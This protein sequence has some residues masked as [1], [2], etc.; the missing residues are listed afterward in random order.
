MKY[1]IEISDNDGN[2]CRVRVTLPLVKGDALP[3]NSRWRALNASALKYRSG[4][5]WAVSANGGGWHP[6]DLNL[7][8]GDEAGITLY[9]FTDWAAFANDSG[10]G[11]IQQPWC[12]TL[13]PYHITWALI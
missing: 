4:G 10:T 9:E 3:T 5:C 11:T 6:M 7:C 1:K 12:L 13:K 8:R 2:V